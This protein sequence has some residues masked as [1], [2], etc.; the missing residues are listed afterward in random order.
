MSLSE[1]KDGVGASVKE[2]DGKVLPVTVA[3]ESG[4]YEQDEEGVP[5]VR[6]PEE[7]KLE[8]ATKLESAEEIPKRRF[9]GGSE[10]NEH[11]SPRQ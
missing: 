10:I 7:S 3:L 1:H 11:Y 5:F 4:G 8:P 9:G 2:H 6:R